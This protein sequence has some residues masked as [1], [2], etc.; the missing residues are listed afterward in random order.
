M[1]AVT[2]SPGGEATTSLTVRNGSDI[3]EAYTL[4]VVGD[5]AAWTTVEPARVS[6]YPGTSET[7]T[8]RLAPPRTPDVR[9]GQLPLGIRV[10]PA[11]HPEAVT[12]PETTVHIEA[13]HELRAE[14]EPH[15]RRG[16]LGARYRTAV[17]N[18]GNTPVDVA[19]GGR[20][21][22]EELRF[23]FTPER[24]ALDPGES[25][26]VGLRV[27]VHRLTWFGP[28]V[29]WPFELD[30][31]E[32][33]AEAAAPAA[34]P[35]PDTSAGP[36]PAD[37]REALRGEFVQLSVLPKWLLAVLAALLA[38]LLAWFTLVRPAVRSA[39]EEAADKA[40]RNSPATGGEGR[41]GDGSGAAPGGKDKPGASPGTGGTDTG[42]GTGAGTGTGNVGGGGGADTV[43]GSARQSS[44]T[45]D[46]QTDGGAEK[47]GTYRVPAG[48]ILGITDVVV[49]NFQGDEGV[50]TITFGDRKITT[51]ALETFRNQDYHWVTPLRVPEN[52]TVT[53]AVTCAKP[54][55]PATGQQASGCHEV[56]NVSGVMSDLKP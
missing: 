54:G 12:V 6:L 2:V 40:V 8:V 15:R 26:E 52:A 23:G 38:L 16:W 13:F 4:D 20:Q 3:V 33:G 9:A 39:A 1:P 10:L 44:A 27:R 29:T 47:V 24:P 25:L 14:L 56:L 21:D 55:T 41:Q 50:L 43:P 34:A 45:I 22:G 5:C 11:E 18:L 7:V 28:P 19:L 48:R 51:I 32:T 36:G 37:R 42:A 31:T 35:A 30:V 46:V 49:A 53:V 17:R